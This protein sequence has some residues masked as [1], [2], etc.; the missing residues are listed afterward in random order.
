[1]TEFTEK[2][3]LLHRLGDAWKRLLNN[4]DPEV[5]G[6]HD[7]AS[8]V[9]PRLALRLAVCSFPSYTKGPPCE[10]PRPH[11]LHSYAASALILRASSSAGE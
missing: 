2:E 8:P 4:P 1:M 5:E 9:A 6:G 7:H 11:R 3:F 10:G